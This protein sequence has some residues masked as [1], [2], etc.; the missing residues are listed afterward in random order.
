MK[1]KKVLKEENDLSA[2]TALPD[3]NSLPGVEGGCLP[4]PCSPS[5][6]LA[7]AYIYDKD[8][9]EIRGSIKFESSYLNGRIDMYSHIPNLLIKRYGG[10]K[11]NEKIR[12][13]RLTQQELHSEWANQPQPER[14]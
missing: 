3:Q 9:K 10:I 13:T 5:S 12:V 2:G 7:Y 14:R 4:H 8:S 11:E 6:E 1:T